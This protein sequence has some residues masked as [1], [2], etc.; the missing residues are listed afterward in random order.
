MKTKQKL[1][2]AVFIVLFLISFS[3][4][5]Q[6]SLPLKNF[7][8]TCSVTINYEV[9]GPNG[10]CSVCQ[11]GTITIPPS[12][13]V[14]MPLCNGWTDICLNIL[15][16]GGDGPSGGHFNLYNTCHS[17][18]VTDSGTTSTTADCPNQNWTADLTSGYF[19][20]Y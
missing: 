6:S 18:I 15:D 8:S 11:W 10:A 7:F 14:M 9:Y 2:F 16:I 4:R 17:G 13:T 5:S 19:W 20:I 1:A 3:A 12:G